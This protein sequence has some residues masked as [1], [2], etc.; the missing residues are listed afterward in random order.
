MTPLAFAHSSLPAPPITSAGRAETRE[1]R[2]ALD[3]TGFLDDVYRLAAVGDLQLATDRVFDYIDRRLLEESFA[4]CNAIL[5]RIDVRKLPAA[6]LRSFLTITYAARE[7]LPA[8]RALYERAFQ[9]MAGSKGHE[10]AQKLLGN[11]A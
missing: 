6:L 10:L 8:R 7:R 3:I 11:L 5:G 9:E 4:V 1:G 2:G